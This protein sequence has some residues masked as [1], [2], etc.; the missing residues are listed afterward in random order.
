L[1]ATKAM[2]LMANP[3]IILRK[4]LPN[5]QCPSRHTRRC[6]LSYPPIFSSAARRHERHRARRSHYLQI[7]SS[8]TR[9]SRRYS[10]YFAIASLR[11]LSN[12][13]SSIVVTDNEV[14]AGEDA[15]C[16]SLYTNTGIPL[17]AARLSSEI[18]Q[19][20]AGSP[21]SNRSPK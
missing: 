1:N 8:G 20:S 14:N 5:K 16:F 17:L 3:S 21:S 19:L 15:A 6:G 4:P 18:A 12:S 10:P 13:F 2:L 11:R 9:S 7:Y